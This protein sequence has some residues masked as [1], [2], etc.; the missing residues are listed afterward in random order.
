MSGTMRIQFLPDMPTA[1]VEVLTPDL[2]TVRQ[3]ALEPGRETTVDVPSEG[4]FIRVHLPSGRSITLRHPGDLNYVVGR[5]DLESRLGRRTSG[6]SRRSPT[7]VQEVRG[8]H[9]FRSVAAG[10]GRARMPS[11]LFGI[12][13]PAA[14]GAV[15]PG[16]IRADWTPEVSGRLSLDGREL[17]FA[18][19]DQMPPYTLRVTDETTRL[20]VTLPGK[21]RSTYVR[22]DD[23]RSGTRLVSVR[24]AT[25]SDM[26]DTVGGALARG[27][28]YAAQAMAPLIDSAMEMLLYK[29]QDPYAAAVGAY[30][31][32]RLERF[33][34]MHDWARNLANMFSF[35]ADGCVI[36][37]WQAFRQHGD[38]DQAA[39]YLLQAVDRGLPVHT[40]GLRL[41]VE[42]LQR[43]GGDSATS[44]LAHLTKLAGRVVWNS[45][46]TTRLESV[47]QTGDIST[48]FDVDYIPVA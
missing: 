1:T 45:P 39:K 16:G 3:V 30:L 48:T 20:A 6:T 14:E 12:E 10:V 19:P 47:P 11:E 7:T 15:L 25:A 26:A 43:L 29:M 35:L 38:V 37:A 5:A 9:G 17:A 28:Y 23:V 46:F 40:E 22:I 24:V 36:W 4:S 33:E 44:A 34:L 21:L 32:L 2:E 8:Y 18:P 27:D 42:G 13:P 31:L 41:L